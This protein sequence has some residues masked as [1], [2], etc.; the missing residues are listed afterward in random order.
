MFYNLLVFNV[1]PCFIAIFQ[2]GAN[3]LATVHFGAFA[4]TFKFLAHDA[5]AYFAHN[6][7]IMGFRAFATASQAVDVF[8]QDFNVVQFAPL[9]GD[10]FS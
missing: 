9:V 3:N 4:A 7:A 6:A 5:L 2:N 8:G 10:F 1:L